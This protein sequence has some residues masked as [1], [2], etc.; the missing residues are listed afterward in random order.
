MSFF[1]YRQGQTLQLTPAYENFKEFKKCFNAVVSDGFSGVFQAMPPEMTIVSKL[2]FEFDESNGNNVIDNEVIGRLAFVHQE[3]VA[4][5]TGNNTAGDL[6]CFVMTHSQSEI[7]GVYV[8]DVYF[9]FPFL[10]SSS[11]YMAERLVANLKHYF[12][13]TGIHC[14]SLSIVPSNTLDEIVSGD[15]YKI[16]YWPL[17]GSY[18]NNSLL[19]ITHVFDRI[20]MEQ[21]KDG[22]IVGYP[23][24]AYFNNLQLP[25][26]DDYDLSNSFFFANLNGFESIKRK[27][28]QREKNRDVTSRMIEERQKETKRTPAELCQIFVSM[29]DPGRYAGEASRNKVGQV[30]FNVLKGSEEGLELWKDSVQWKLEAHNNAFPDL[31]GLAAKLGMTVSQVL[32]TRSNFPDSEPLRKSDE[33]IQNII[34][35]IQAT[36]DT[37]WAYFE[38]TEMT[39]GTLKFWAKM[40]NPEQY[41]A[42]M[43]KDIITLAWRCLNPTSSHT[44][45]AKLI[46]A[47]YSS[48]VVCANIRDN[49]WFGY[50]E[51]KWQELDKASWLRK[52]ISDDLPALFE[53]ILD[54]CGS[55]Y[56]RAVG[57][58]D[59]EKWSKL[60]NAA[61]RMIKD[62]KTVPY[63][64][65]IITESAERFY[66]PDFLH[67]A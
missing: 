51:H 38:Y 22:K 52:K 43:Q 29:L 13:Q 63:K 3:A 47:K 31:E 40:D 37:I 62:V 4:G 21:V 26:N 20:T 18:V 55:E 39:I 53:R 9:Q 64:N 19:Q 48:E 58:E 12:T 24:E 15:I 8:E 35:T 45:V 57:D 42:F 30:L 23:P 6:T 59:K 41:A 33:E 54:E 61:S 25:G 49:T 5:T 14:D 56:R 1:T 2:R 27:K 44:D 32:A 50:W 36:C 28:T 7:N 46:H 67:Q 17:P 65:H 16:G 60:M 10:K 11:Q 34:E 66:D